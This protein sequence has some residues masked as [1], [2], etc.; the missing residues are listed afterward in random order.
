MKV[1]KAVAIQYQSWFSC[2]VR[3][4]GERQRGCFAGRNPVSILVFIPS[5]N[6]ST[7]ELVV[8]YSSRNPV[9]ILVFIP[10]LWNYG[11]AI[12][13]PL[14]SQSSINPGFHSELSIR[15][16]SDQQQ[17]HCRNPV[18]ILVFIPS[19]FTPAHVTV[20]SAESQ[21]SINPGF[22]SERNPRLSLKQ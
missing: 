2:R 1:G 14:G 16:T 22:H 11:M 15:S 5:Y 21:S 18:S 9:S 13:L 8:C 6:I 4:V 7:M 10:R 20:P 19:G 3:R 17:S 12:S